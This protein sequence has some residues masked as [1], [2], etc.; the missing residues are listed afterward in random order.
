MDL[1]CHRKSSEASWG[2]SAGS[3]SWYGEGSMAGTWLTA[4]MKRGSAL[5]V[6]S[7]P[8]GQHSGIAHTQPQYQS[9]IWLNWS[10]RLAYTSFI[11]SSNGLTNFQNWGKGNGERG[12]KLSSISTPSLTLPFTLKD[13]KSPG[14]H[15]IYLIRA[16]VS[17]YSCVSVLKALQ[18]HSYFRKYRKA[19][20]EWEAQFSSRLLSKVSLV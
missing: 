13:M 4:A 9:H 10:V 6:A 17:R 2:D 8:S 5:G 1:T 18:P 12:F 15:T 14:N 7:S 19:F 16:D 20:V 11:Y 3:V